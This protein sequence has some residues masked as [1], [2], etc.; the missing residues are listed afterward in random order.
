MNILVVIL[1]VLHLRVCA[2]ALGAIVANFKQPKVASAVSHGLYLAVGAGLVITGIAGAMQWNLNYAKIGIKLVVAVV[3]TVMAVVGQKRPE[4][5]TTGY[6]AGL[7]GLIVT[8]VALAVLWRAP[9]D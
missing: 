7:V 9:E 3:A 5:I 8:N 4:K 6:L 1:F 2:V